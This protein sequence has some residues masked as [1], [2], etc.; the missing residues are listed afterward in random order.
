[1]LIQFVHLWEYV[2]IFIYM[3]LSMC[4]SMVL[5]ICVFLYGVKYVL[6][7]VVLCNSCLFFSI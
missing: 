6:G 1:M 3:V 4:I 7:F 2:Y 5:S